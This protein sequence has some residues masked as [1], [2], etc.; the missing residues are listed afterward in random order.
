V[1][2]SAFDAIGRVTLFGARA[3]R[4]V[5]SPP[6]E[7]DFLLN[8]LYQIGVGSFSLVVAAGFALG[9]VMTLHTR[10]TLVQFGATAE[11]P[12]FQA[13]SFFVELGPLVT[14]LLVAGRV[15]AGMGAELANM[16]ATEQIDAIETL[17]VDSFKLLVVTRVIAC[18]AM[19]P[20][21]TLFTDAAGILGGFISEH[22]IS[23][24]SWTL[25]VQR[26]FQ[27]ATFTDF[28]PP[29]VKTAVF[30][31]LIATISCFY[32]Y[33]TNEGSAGVRKAATKSVVISS[34]VIILA[35]VIL[36]KCIFFLFPDSAI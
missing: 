9:V 19:V 34:L 33:T 31:F 23:H 35:D 11:I 7:G 20:L 18:T 27:G 24:L 17:S 1:L 3:L 22:M 14:A 29:T 5:W 36:V 4:D 8:Q 15:G 32:G 30:G 13:L 16:R 28:V 6:F 21:L 25:Y 12:T 2:R 26:A 10:S